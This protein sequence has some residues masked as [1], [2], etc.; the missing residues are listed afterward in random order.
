MREVQFLPN[1]CKIQHS[2]K[3]NGGTNGLPQSPAITAPLGSEIQ[4]PFNLHNKLQ[5][6]KINEGGDRLPYSRDSFI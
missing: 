4:P 5:R 1:L 3:T 6:T 2:T